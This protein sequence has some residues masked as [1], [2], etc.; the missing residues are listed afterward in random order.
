MNPEVN[1]RYKISKKAIV[2]LREAA[3]HVKSNLDLGE[4]NTFFEGD[5][6]VYTRRNDTLGDQNSCKTSR[7]RVG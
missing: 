3:F 7:S 6:T 5:G 2:A 4:K 1:I